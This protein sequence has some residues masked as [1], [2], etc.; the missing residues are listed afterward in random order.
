MASINKVIEQVDK[1]RSNTF[2]DEQKSKWLSD[3]EGM[4]ARVVYQ[5]E[6]VIYAFPDD[7][8]KELSVQPPFDGIYDLYLQAQIALHQG[9]IEDYNNILLMFDTRFGEFK[10]AYIRGNRPKSA[11]LFINL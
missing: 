8:D 1:L 9:E 6:P 2:S 4:I 3:M 7:A 11:G 5:Q 10:K